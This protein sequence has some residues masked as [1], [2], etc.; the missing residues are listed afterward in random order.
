MTLL[1][2]ESAVLFMMTAVL[3]FLIP[4]RSRW[5]V[6]L[7]SSIIFYFYGGIGTGFFMVLTIVCIYVT[8]LW[9]DRYN[10]TQREYL[11]D[12]PDLSRTEKKTYRGKIQHKKRLILALGLVI[13]FGFLVYLKDFNFL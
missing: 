7:T 13:C 12:H 2:F 3:Y 4:L 10:Q 11:K 5:I 1:S 8:A 6:L 9:L